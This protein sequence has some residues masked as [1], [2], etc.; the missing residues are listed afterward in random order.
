MSK[1]PFVSVC[2]LTYK[3]ADILP[4]S[5]DTLLAQTHG[6]FELI[7]CDDCSPDHTEQV[8]RAYEKRDPRVRYC[9]NERNL[10]Y[11]GNQ[12][13][14]IERARSDYVAIVHDG[15]IYRPDLIEKW[16][17]ALVKYP[18]AALV[19]NA[20]EALDD[21]G[22]KVVAVHRHP[23]FPL[24][25]GKELFDEM[26]CRWGSPI[27]GIIMVRKSCVKSVGAFDTQFPVLA[28]VDMWLRLLLKYDAAYIDEPLLRIAMKEKQHIN[29]EVNW[30]I[31]AE[32]ERIHRLNAQRR[33]PDDKLK[34]K[35]LSRQLDRLFLRERLSILLHCLKPRRWMKIPEGVWGIFRICAR[36]WE[37]VES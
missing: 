29:R 13:A 24:T 28:D 12:N 16:V 27:F 9:R 37:A 36:R 5:L 11:A 19:F 23:Y 14:A 22:E 32:T 21:S 2:L 8:A 35:Q 6:D 33:Y 7:I 18:T 30:S 1:L 10:R 25:S 17:G 4:R 31:V 34:H 26:I 15:D 3:R 20:L